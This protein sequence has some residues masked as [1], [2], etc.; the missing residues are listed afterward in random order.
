MEE[1][2]REREREREEEEEEEE[3]EED[4][5]LGAVGLTGVS[6]QMS[7]F[8][9]LIECLSTF[10]VHK[11]A[12]KRQGAQDEQDINQQGGSM[13]TP[14]TNYGTHHCVR[15]ERHH[16]AGSLAGRLIACNAIISRKQTYQ[17]PPP[18]PS[19]MGRTCKSHSFS[20]TR[21]HGHF[22]CFHY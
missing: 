18:P 10:H 11:P 14:D 9:T 17:Y 4:E 6:M 21:F 2:E 1:R 7:A 22:C 20:I 16:T 12:C 13:T 8:L 5:I 3:E 19:M 15:K